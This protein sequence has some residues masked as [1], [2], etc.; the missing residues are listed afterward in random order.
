MK[1]KTIKFPFNVF[2]FIIFA[3]ICLMS[4]SEIAEAGIGSHISEPIPK[5]YG[6]LITAMGTGAICSNCSNGFTA[7]GAGFII[8]IHYPFTLNNAND[9]TCSVQPNL[10]AP[11]AMINMFS[12]QPAQAQFAVFHPATGAP[13]TTLAS[14]VFVCHR[15]E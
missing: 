11:T 12:F 8:T 4:Y 5:V 7:S 9:M 14:A 10:F 3:W 6:G 13:V 15:R 2:A 1:I